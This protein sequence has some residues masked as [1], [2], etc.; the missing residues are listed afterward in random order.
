M[1]EPRLEYALQTSEPERIFLHY[2]QLLTRNNPLPIC[3]ELDGEEHPLD[4]TMDYRFDFAWPDSR[5]AVEIDGG[6][7]KPGGGR[8]GSD[9]DRHKLNLAAIAGWRVMR[10][11]PKMLIDDPEQCISEVVAAL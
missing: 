11:S 5:L 2:W 10:Y 6:Q 9:T 3:Q 8:H 7:W 4:E 1:S